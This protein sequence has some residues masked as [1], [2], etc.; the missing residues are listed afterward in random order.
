MGDE[1]IDEALFDE[2]AE[3]GMVLTCQMVP[4]SDCVVEIPAAVPVQ[5][6]R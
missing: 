2:E 1:Y 4:S 6:G 3:Q 5:Q